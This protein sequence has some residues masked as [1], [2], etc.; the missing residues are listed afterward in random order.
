M[1][2]TDST[3]AA[4]TGIVG[5]ALAISLA[6]QV[7]AQRGRGPAASVAA[8]TD[9]Q[10]LERIAASPTSAREVQGGSFA[11]MPKALRVAAYA[12]LGA[13][14]SPESLA[15]IARIER[16]MSATPLTPATVPMDGWPTVGAHMGDMREAPIA[17][18]PPRGETTYAVALGSLLGGND[19]FL[20][21]TRTPDDRA[22]WSRPKL[23]APVPRNVDVDDATLAWRGPRTLTLTSGTQRLQVPIDGIDRDS[24][25]DGWTDVEEARLGT[26]PRNSDSDGDGIPDGR[27]VC[28]LYAAPRGAADETSMILQ[29]AL[30][31]ALAMTGSRQLLYVTPGTPRVHLEGYGGPILFDRAIPKSGDG[32]GAT[33][34]SWTIRSRTAAEAVV[35]VTDWEGVLAAGGQNVLLKKIDGRWVVVGVRSTWVS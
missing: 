25:G 35:E 12:R 29:R 1:H 6:P 19:Y 8:S 7:R 20:V 11:G 23:I 18:A 14:G 10:W 28:P 26:D 31:G 30:F 17:K 16:A 2:G 3:R 4:L 34:V 5:I 33:Y 15:A 24:D 27:D 21:S 22:S 13:I 32:D 9:V